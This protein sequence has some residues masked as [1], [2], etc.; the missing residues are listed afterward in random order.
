LCSRIQGKAARSE[1]SAENGDNTHDNKN[2]LADRIRAPQCTASRVA[3][4]N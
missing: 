3:T 2:T 1:T 4:G